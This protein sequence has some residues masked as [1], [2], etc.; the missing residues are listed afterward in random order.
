MLTR[1]RLMQLSFASAVAPQLNG[2]RA[3][4]Q[5]WPNRPVR[6]I[7]PLA[8][9]GA[10]DATARIIGARLADRWGQQVVIE[11]KTGAATNIAAEHVAR[12]TPDGY[13]LYIT[14]FS[15]ATNR[16][17]YPSLNYDPIGD[18]APVTLIG[19]YPNIMVVPMSSPARTVKEFIAFAKANKGNVSY[20]SSGHGTSL[21][22]AGELFQRMAGIE[23]THIP[24]RGGGPAFN[25]LIPG[26]VDVMINLTVASLPLVRNGQLRALGMATA[27]RVPVVPELPTISESGVPGFEVSS[28]AAFFMPAKTP[29]DIVRKVHADTVAVLAEPVVKQ[30]LEEV[31]VVLVGS[32]PNDLASH[33]KAEMDKWGPIIKQ[34]GITMRD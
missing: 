24:Y 20:A 14:S 15:H 34:I 21:H 28:W 10:I 11:N 13:T 3:N 22:L 16:F 26:R 6:L 33:L 18:F 12:S 1:R 7:V 31:G 27:K 32:T 5:D 17:L 8:A 25:D 29:P 23:M 9:G 2:R 4:A 19:I 30:R